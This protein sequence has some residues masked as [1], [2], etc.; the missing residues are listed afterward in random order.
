MVN[1]YDKC[2]VLIYLKKKFREKYNFILT[3]IMFKSK[4]LKK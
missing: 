3:K 1:F 2:Y 4:G